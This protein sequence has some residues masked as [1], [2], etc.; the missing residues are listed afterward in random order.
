MP[1]KKKKNKPTKKVAAV[2]ARCEECM[3]FQ[4]TVAV[5]FVF[6]PSYGMFHEDGYED[7]PPPCALCQLC[8]K[9]TCFD[10]IKRVSYTLDKNSWSLIGDVCLDCYAKLVKRPLDFKSRIH[11]FHGMKSIP[12][13]I[14][15]QYL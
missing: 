3:H 8:K 7:P 14:K 12:K 6:S 5:E 9:A 11:Q 4:K 15:F 10:C 2:Q 1:K 13:S